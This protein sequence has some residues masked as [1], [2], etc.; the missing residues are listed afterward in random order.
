MSTKRPSVNTALNTIR[1]YMGLYTDYRKPKAIEAFNRLQEELKVSKHSKQKYDELLRM[2][3]SYIKRLHTAEEENKRLK[4]AAKIYIADVAEY[5][6]SFC[7]AVGH[8]PH[9]CSE[10]VLKGLI[11]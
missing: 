1:E 9:T 5:G 7:N 8:D 10:C 11:Q 3:E 4:E 2:T 6:E